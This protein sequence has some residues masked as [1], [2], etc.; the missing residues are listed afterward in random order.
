MWHLCRYIQLPVARTFLGATC[1][2][3]SVTHPR[4]R[5]RKIARVGLLSL[6]YSCEAIFVRVIKAQE[7][8][9]VERKAREHQTRTNTESTE[10]TNNPPKQKEGGRPKRRR[11]SK[12]KPDSDRR[13][14]NTGHS[15]RVLLTSQLHLLKK[16]KK[17]RA[18]K[19]CDVDVPDELRLGHD[20]RVHLARGSLLVAR[21]RRLESTRQPQK[22]KRTTKRKR[23]MRKSARRDPQS[24]W[25]K[26][27]L[28][29]EKI[30]G[31]T[32]CK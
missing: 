19:R 12:P 21:H 28:L 17:P 24:P 9:T 11:Q 1:P 25:R 3:P 27:P 2:G 6:I 31:P 26:T 15:N 18:P 4:C 10:S 32:K 13:N 30:C 29:P 23:S 16:K 5:G 7:R 8:S 14:K 20:D 22:K